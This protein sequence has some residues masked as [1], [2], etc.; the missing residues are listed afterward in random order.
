[1]FAN[2]KPS[3]SAKESKEAIANVR[4]KK[5]E[6][7]SKTNKGEKEENEVSTRDLVAFMAAHILSRLCKVIFNFLGERG[8]NCRPAV[9]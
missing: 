5:T 2:L 1:M 4:R 7:A 3:S 9:G 6:Q 8:G